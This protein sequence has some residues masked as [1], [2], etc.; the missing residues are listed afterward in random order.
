[1]QKVAILYDVSQ[2]VLSTF[3]LDEVLSQILMIA[4][5]YFRVENCAILL[6]DP[7]DQKLRVRKEFGG[8]RIALDVAIPLGRGIIGSAAKRKLPIYAPDVSKDSRYIKTFSE[9][10]CELAI[11]LVVRDEVYGVLDFQSVQLNY[12][13]NDTI[14]LLTLFSTQA[15]IALANARLYSDQQRQRA[16]LEAINAIADQ[17]SKTNELDDLLQKICSLIPEKFSVDHAVLILREGEPDEERLLMR[18]HSGRLTPLFAAHYELPPGDGHSRTAYHCAEVVVDKDVRN[19]QG[20]IPGFKETLSELCVPMIAFQ[21]TLG[22]LVLDSARAD[23]FKP[24]DIRALQSVADI[25]AVGIRNAMQLHQA[26]TMASTDG[27]TGIYNRRGFETRIIEEIAGAQRNGLGV[28]LLMV[29]IDHFKRLNDEFGHLLGDEVLRQ[30][31]KIFTQQIRKN[32]IVCRYGG[33]EFAI[34]LPETTTERA[35]AVAEKLRRVVAEYQFPGVPRPVTISL[36]IAD[37]PTHAASRDDL[38]RAADEALYAAKQNGRNRTETA[39][40]AVGKTV[41]R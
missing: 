29:D 19:S 21:E 40:Q 22:V 5:D 18:A 33:E 7:S 14:D 3:D 2:A 17:I 28:S 11:P 15:S 13:D 26:K 4:Q 8:N 12:F 25:C 10:R 36:G 35:H 6:F 9:T 32:D 16:Q 38:V 34:L 23:N 41:A 27:L 20:Y 37:S 31:A 30:V 24:E 39:Q 1:M